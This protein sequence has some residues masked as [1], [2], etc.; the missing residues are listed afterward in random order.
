MEDSIKKSINS[1]IEAAGN[2][3]EKTSAIA[4]IT[5]SIIDCFKSG[6]KILICG[7]GGSAADAQHMAAELVGRFKKDRQ[8]LAAISLT[9]DTSVISAV[10]NDFGIEYIFSKQI[11]A[12]GKPADRLIL[13]STSGN[14]KNLINAAQ[15]AQELKIETIGILGKNGGVLADKVN[16]HITVN[17]QDTARI[18]EMHGLIIHAIC[19]IVENSLGVD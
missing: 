17:S 7:N 12:T 8:P 15:T 19:E 13:I 18:Q 3:L 16:K 5:Q 11:K 14:S 10:G 1:N 6:G 4:E 9:T 2:L